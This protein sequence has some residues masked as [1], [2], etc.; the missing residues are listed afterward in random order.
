[1]RLAA[2]RLDLP[3][4]AWRGGRIHDLV[5][6]V[7]RNYDPGLKAR[8]ETRVTANETGSGYDQL[9]D[10]WNSESF[11]RSNAIAQHERALAFCHNNRH[12]LDIGCGSS[13]RII[14]LLVSAGIESIEGVDVSE[15]MIDLAK[16]RHPDVTFHHADICEWQFPRKY[17]L[18]SAWDSIWHVPLARQAPL[19][20]TICRSLAAD[21]VCIFTIGGLDHPSE[22]VDSAMGPRMYYGTLGIPRTIEVLAGSG[23]VLR[24]L[25][26][27]Q[28]P[29]LH[30]YVIAQ[31]VA[32]GSA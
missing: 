20:E 29:E 22:K 7:D 23:C 19:L 31:R 24:H 8:H 30:V 15:R 1:M 25:E 18:I 5:V 32:T 12:A 27:D 16:R 6:G 10:L 17:D 14:D 11:P 9:A 3:V 21:G 2:V 13:G 28:Y 26:Y 4:P